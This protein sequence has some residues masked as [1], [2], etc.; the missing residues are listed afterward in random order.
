MQRFIASRKRPLIE[1]LVT[2]GAAEVA[3]P[4]LSKATGM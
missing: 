3:Q 2:F 1:C 4:L